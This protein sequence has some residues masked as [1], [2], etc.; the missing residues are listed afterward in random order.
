MGVQK[1]VQRH[2]ITL[3]H[4]PFEIR[5]TVYACAAGCSCDGALITQRATALR[6]RLPPKGI[7]GYDVTVFVGLARFLEHRQ[8]EEI[9][10]ALE[11]QH[12]IVI[13]TGE[14]SVLCRR[15]LSYLEALHDARAEALRDALAKDGGWPLHIDATGEDGR[16]TLLVAYAGWRRWV[17]GAWKIPTERAEAIFPRLLDVTRRFGAPCAIMRDLGR[18]MKEASEKLVATLGTDVPI[19]ACHLHFLRDVGGD[20]LGPAHD[21]LRGL[22]RRFKVRPRLR[23]LAR[24]LGRS[25]GTRIASARQGLSHWQD[26]DDTEHVVPGGQAGLATVRALAQWVL[27]YPRDGRDQGFPFDLPY[28]DF[29][30]RCR[31]AGRAADAF[32]RREIADR[33]VGKNLQRL[34]RILQPVEN[35]GEFSKTAATLRANAGLFTELRRAL[36]LSPESAARNAT[37]SRVF[38]PGQAAREIQNVQTATDALTASLK[39]RRPERGPAHEQRKAIDTILAH[40]QR[41]R[42]FLFGH[43]IHVPTSSGGGVRVVDRTNN[44]LEGFFDD[45][46]HGERRRSGRKILTQDL[47][48]L[49]P[50]AALTANLRSS[51]YVAIVCGSLDKLPNAFAVLDRDSR[52]RSSI[53]TRAAAHIPD[54]SDCDVVSASLPRADRDLVRTPGMERRVLAAARSRAPRLSATG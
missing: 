35:H 9:R 49:P 52:R 16:G 54:A 17:L 46:K 7:I 10:S 47:E 8:R 20:L 34:R 6:D 25:L 38:T 45:L 21:R 40:L 32:L 13:S 41:H 18:A 3:E 11:V 15:F 29:D 24:D 26:G 37:A 36:R 42:P 28:L 1:T 14:V 31:T 4:G 39:D 22:F 50:A 23:A 19:L 53:L 30:Q 43:V 12:G 2:G 44:L 5:E 33:G 48:Q 51:D 27:D